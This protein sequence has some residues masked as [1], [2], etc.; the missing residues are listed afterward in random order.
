MINAINCY[1]SDS[2][3]GIPKGDLSYFMSLWAIQC[4]APRIQ[5]G[6]H[7]GGRYVPCLYWHS[8]LPSRRG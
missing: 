8:I 7:S 3:E 5:W 1:C 4:M 2:G 6:N